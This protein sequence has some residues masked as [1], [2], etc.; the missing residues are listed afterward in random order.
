MKLSKTTKENSL[1]CVECWQKTENHNNNKVD[2]IKQKYIIQH[3]NAFFVSLSS[4]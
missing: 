2:V 1:I 3:I 4:Q